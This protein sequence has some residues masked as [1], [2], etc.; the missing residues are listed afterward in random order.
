MKRVAAAVVGFAF[1][2]RALVIFETPFMPMGDSY[3]RLLQPREIVK[4]VW[5]P[6]YQA[7]LAFV[8]LFSHEVVAFR[9][10]TAAQ[11]ALAA[12]AMALLA[13]R[14]AGTAS[15]VF[16]GLAVSVLPILVLTGLYQE[17]LFLFATSAGLYALTDPEARHDV[18]AAGFLS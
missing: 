6:A 15:A 12:G 11:S 9:L 17:S 14:V 3:A 2:V 10:A 4:S 1:A 5:L 16:V 8:D 13:S 18:A 7:T